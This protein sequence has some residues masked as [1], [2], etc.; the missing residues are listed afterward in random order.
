MAFFLS[1]KT[2]LKQTYFSYGL[3]TFAEQNLMLDCTSIYILGDNNRKQGPVSMHLLILVS[4]L[5]LISL[6]IMLYPY[7]DSVIISLTS[8][9]QSSEKSSIVDL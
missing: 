2:F 4:D 1:W 5:A 3:F 7:T 8:Y 6:Q 9:P